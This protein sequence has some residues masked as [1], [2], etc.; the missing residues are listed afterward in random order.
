[1]LEDVLINSSGYLSASKQFQIKC[2]CEKTS[3]KPKGT[4]L[5]Q[6]WV[7]LCI[8]LILDV[9]VQ[10]VSA[11]PRTVSV[12]NRCNIL[13][14][15]LSNFDFTDFDLWPWTLDSYSNSAY[16]IPPVDDSLEFQTWTSLKSGSWLPPNYLHHLEAKA[17]PIPL[18][19]RLIK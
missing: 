13:V 7:F 15:W 16:M 5:G 3:R 10:C 6:V 12:R 2:K 17:P 9:G 8:S 19:L 14:G 1:M 18:F 11:M 4:G